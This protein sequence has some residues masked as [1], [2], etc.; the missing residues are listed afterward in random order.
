MPRIRRSLAAALTAVLPLTAGPAFAAQPTAQP[1]AEPTAARPQ[2]AAAATLDG[3]QLQRQLE[4]AL[5]EG[6]GVG[7]VAE[8]A[9]PDGTWRSSAGVAQ[10]K[11]R[12]PASPSARFRAASVTKSVVS[13]LALQLVAE[14]RWTLNTTI[15]DVLPRL[16][17]ERSGITLRQLLSH[18][19]GMP[20]MV[21]PLLA[22]AT[23]NAEFLRAIRVERTD[24]ELVEAAKKAE[25][26]F[27]PGT[28]MKYSNTN[29]VVV[30]MMLRQA[31]GQNVA[32]LAEHRVFEP[33]RMHQS[34]LARS[35][36]IQ[37]ARLHEYGRLGGRLHDLGGFSPTIFSSSGSLV[38]TTRD[39]N[40]FHR[41][42]STGVLLPKPLVREMRSVVAV[43]QDTGAEYGLGSYRMPDPCRPGGFLH[44]HDGGTYG[45]VT[46][47][48]SSPD[49]RRRVT[50]ASTGRTLSLQSPPLMQLMA[51]VFVAA[52]QSCAG[53]PVTLKRQGMAK[54]LPLAGIPAVQLPFS[55]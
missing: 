19:S 12:I 3:P 24:R 32:H 11:P 7:A 43:D 27:E 10:K 1:T 15:G 39:L 50:V 22:E 20:D 35:K 53:A 38:S 25:W 45:T 28:D 46:L 21:A 36:Y 8:V 4:R 31:T 55:G 33:A 17:P 23:T 48:F 16:W 41:A 54:P 29:Y 30:G 18:S 9:T 44:G 49:G 5:T 14:G 42:L 34:K 51:F 13:V 40:R 37:P 47:T 52:E 2:Q 26:L 6:G